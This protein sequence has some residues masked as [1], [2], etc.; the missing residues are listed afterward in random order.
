MWHESRRITFG[1]RGGAS[2]LQH[3][4]RGGGRGGG[5][6]E[7]EQSVMTHIYENAITKPI[8]LYANF[9]AVILEDCIYS[10][11]WDKL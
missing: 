3:R 7:L 11:K 8:A 2:K 4:R 6:S 1:G 10:W 9:K 5:Q